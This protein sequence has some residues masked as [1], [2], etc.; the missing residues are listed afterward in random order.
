MHVWVPLGSSPVHACSSGGGVSPDRICHDMLLLA[1]SAAHAAS[2]RMHQCR[3]MSF[4]VRTSAMDSKDGDNC[5]DNRKAVVA[6]IVLNQR[7]AVCGMQVRLAGN[8]RTTTVFA[9]VVQSKQGRAEA[10][11]AR[12]R[13]LCLQLPP[14]TATTPA[15]DSLKHQPRQCYP[16][17]KQD[18][19]SE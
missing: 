18:I 6:G 9:A 5:W 14:L 19:D 4:N 15:A 12:C 8:C 3:V 16:T 11:C 7:P 1:Y 13:H 17:T 2:K 10:V